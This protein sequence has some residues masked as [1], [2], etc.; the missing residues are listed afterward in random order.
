MLSSPLGGILGSASAKVKPTHERSRNP[1]SAVTFSLS[2]TIEN[3]QCPPR[4]SRAWGLDYTG[5][6]IATNKGWIG[7]GSGERKPLLG[8]PESDRGGDNG[9]LDP[10][11]RLSRQ[12]VRRWG[13]LA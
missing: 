7:D 13:R 2:G 1:Q 10:D 4:L 11:H 6:R 12:E 3:S 9:R 8:C 5:R